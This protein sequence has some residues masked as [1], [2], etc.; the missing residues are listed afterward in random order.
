MR[1]FDKYI[2]VPF[3]ER[4]RGPSGLDCWGLVR[5]VLKE[6][7]GIERP[8]YSTDC[9]THETS[10]AIIRHTNSA[11][12]IEIDPPAQRFDMAVMWSIA[13]RRRLLMHVGIVIA[14]NLLLH[15]EPHTG[16]VVVDFTDPAVR[17]RINRFLRPY[18]LSASHRAA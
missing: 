9:F 4:G 15:T 17:H 8:E 6:Q 16:S 1:C 18:E 11:D 7:A 13:G 10:Q 3:I 2:G 14:P 12:W 5:L